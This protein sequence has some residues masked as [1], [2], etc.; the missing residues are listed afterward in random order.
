[1]LGV[2]NGS[3]GG[4]K[5]LFVCVR[6]EA[7]MLRPR[8]LKVRTDLPRAA[9]QFSV[10]VPVPSGRLKY[11]PDVHTH[12]C[13]WVISHHI[14]LGTVQLV[15]SSPGRVQVYVRNKAL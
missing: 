6:N 9:P 12:H 2:P 11:R 1:M 10:Q 8:E 4:R 14:T 13:G 3:D 15:A 7:R 5:F